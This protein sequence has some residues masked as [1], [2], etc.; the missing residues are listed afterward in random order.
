MNQTYLIVRTRVPLAPLDCA[1][2]LAAVIAYHFEH[3]HEPLVDGE[4]TTNL[5]YSGHAW[6]QVAED[7]RLLDLL[8]D[9]GP[10]VLSEGIR[11]VIKDDMTF[12]A[13]DVVYAAVMSAELE[14]VQLEPDVTTAVVEWAKTHLDD[15]VRDLYHGQSDL[16]IKQAKHKALLL[17]QRAVDTLM[18]KGWAMRGGALIP[19]K[20][21]AG[22]LRAEAREAKRLAGPVAK[23]TKPKARPKP[24]KA[25]KH[26]PGPTPATPP[27]DMSRD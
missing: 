16:Q 2:F 19:P 15:A 13:L 22:D 4:S 1:Q 3:G 24:K 12:D 6:A 10:A 9:L 25:K 21:W 11:F 20:G 27:G 14:D 26:R 8:L 23:K 18:Q 5:G 7:P 17:E